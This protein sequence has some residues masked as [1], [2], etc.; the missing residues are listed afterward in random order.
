MSHIKHIE[1]RTWPRPEPA[2][3]AIDPRA[4]VPIGR[5]WRR[6]PGDVRC[7]R[8]VHCLALIREAS[9]RVRV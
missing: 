4:Y 5:A 6:S 2:F 8:S 1:S 3:R 7:A 9:P